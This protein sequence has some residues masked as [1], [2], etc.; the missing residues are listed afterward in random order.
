MQSLYGKIHGGGI[1]MND[2][3]VKEAIFFLRVHYFDNDKSWERI[4]G[5]YG[6]TTHK[7]AEKLKAKLER[8]VEESK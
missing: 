7:W 6:G 1:E 3:P 2:D 5:F 4:I 8:Y